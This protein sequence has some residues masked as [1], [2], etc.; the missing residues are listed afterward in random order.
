MREIKWHYIALVHSSTDL[1]IFSSGKYFEVEQSYK[2]EGLY[3]EQY[4]GVRRCGVVGR[5][6]VFHPGGPGSIPGRVR[7]F[8]FYPGAE[9]LSFVFCLVFWSTVCYSHYRYL[10]QGHVGCKFRG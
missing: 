3:L 9:C 4:V 10:T 5:V 6:P 2:S 7:N 1:S 8:N